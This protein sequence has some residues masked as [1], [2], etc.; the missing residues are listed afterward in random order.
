METGKKIEE[1]YVEE[2]KQ[3]IV[4]VMPKLTVRERRLLYRFTYAQI[5]CNKHRGEADFVKEAFPPVPQLT[6]RVKVL[7]REAEDDEVRRVFK[8][9]RTFADRHKKKE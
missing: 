5:V 1:V 2:M 6:S 4:R 8:L 3:A 9:L 7:L